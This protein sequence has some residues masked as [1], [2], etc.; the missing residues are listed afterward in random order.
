MAAAY[1]TAAAARRHIPQLRPH[2]LPVRWPRRR[3][4]VWGRRMG[5]WKGSGI[6]MCADKS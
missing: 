5:R 2:L 3:A 6:Q 1:L 4:A